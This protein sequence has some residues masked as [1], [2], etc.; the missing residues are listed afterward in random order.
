MVNKMK[1]KRKVSDEEDGS[2]ELLVTQKTFVHALPPHL[3][4]LGIIS[5]YRNPHYHGFKEALL[6]I[7]DLHTETLN[8]WTHLLGFFYFFFSMFYMLEAVE[9]Q[10]KKAGRYLGDYDH[11]VFIIYH[12][13]AC[14]QMITSA[15]Y[16]SFGFLS[17]EMDN[18]LLRIDITGIILMI[19]GSYIIGMYHGFRCHT[20]YQ[21]LYIG[22]LGCML[23]IAA[24][25]TATKAVQDKRIF[26][27]RNIVLV[28]AVGFGIIPGIHYFQHCTLPNCGL[29]SPFSW[30]MIG[31][32][33]SYGLG[34]VFYSTKWPESKYHG[35]FDI[36]FHSH[37]IWHA[38]IFVAGIFWQ[39]GMLNL[40]EQQLEHLECNNI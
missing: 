27:I 11:I 36:F 33:S 32:L 1:I 4:R 40:R 29:T 30:G 7:F 3:K 15:I 22:V 35:K 5:G 2:Q 16:H 34:F 19:L 18:F 28:L 37:Q 21:A 6:S 25:L 24:V 17:E 14:I 31:M 26:Q 8:I 20:G 39:L 38:L 23:S 10:S 9:E 12:A 13:G